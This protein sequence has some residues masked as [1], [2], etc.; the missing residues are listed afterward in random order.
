[1]KKATKKAKETYCAFFRVDLTV[2]VTTSATFIS[3]KVGILIP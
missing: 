3:T 1:M 2:T